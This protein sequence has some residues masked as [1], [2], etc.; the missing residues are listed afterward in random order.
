VLYVLDTSALIDAWRKWYSPHSIPTFW[1]RLE[2]LGADGLAA[3][4]DAVL[5]E[6]SDQDD[7]VY[8]WVREREERLV[9]ESDERVQEIVARISADYPAY[10]N[11]A[12]GGK[13]FADP[14]VIATAK[15]NGCAVVTHERATGDMNGPRM[16]DVCRAEQI[17]PLQMYE[18]V[19]L[20]AWVFS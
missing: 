20:A 5:L 18:L 4:P 13:N 19:Q 2:Q 10:R 15:H 9:C 11:T 16:P 7:D 3:I 14:F 6:L 17:R 1:T 8:R 12:P